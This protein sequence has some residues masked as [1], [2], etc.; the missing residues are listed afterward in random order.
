[1]PVSS[2]AAVRA[3]CRRECVEACKRRCSERALDVQETNV[4]A[5]R[6][7]CEDEAA[8]GPGVPEHGAVR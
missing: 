2:I 3:A 7:G 5:C 4:A 8:R 6:A 1:M